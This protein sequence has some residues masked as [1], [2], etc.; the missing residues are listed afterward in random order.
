MLKRSVLI[1]LAMVLVYNTCLRS[2]YF[3]NLFSVQSQWQ[4]NLITA[5]R[6]TLADTAPKIVLVGSSLSAQIPKRLL[7]PDIYNL[8]FA[9]GSLFTGLEL[10]ESAKAAPHLVVIEMNILFRNADPQLLENISRPVFAKL[11]PMVPALQEQWQPANVLA[12]KLTRVPLEKLSVMK[13]RLCSP[14]ISSNEDDLHKRMVAIALE[15]N[16]TPLPPDELTRQI[17]LLRQHIPK[18]QARGI[19][20]AFLEMPTDS[21]IAAS[22]RCAAIRAKMLEEFPT[23]KYLWISPDQK[24][25][26]LTTDGQH[27][28]LKEAEAYAL[29]I[30]TVIQ[31]ASGLPSWQSA[32]ASK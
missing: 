31:Q 12:G 13:S 32:S 23:T 1:A 9:G 16:R 18:L 8:S 7:E 4:N 11:R 24:H 19:Q 25:T 17:A 27:L 15:N 22:P 5:Q 2:S 28:Q 14:S 20:C 26:Y 30:R 10:V 6:Y 29:H 21:A 3:R